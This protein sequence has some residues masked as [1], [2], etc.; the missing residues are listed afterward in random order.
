MRKKDNILLKTPFMTVVLNLLVIYISFMLCRVVFIWYNWNVF[1]GNLDKDVILKML[2]GALKFDTAGIMY[3]TLPYMLLTML[4]FHF[5]ENRTYYTI[6]KVILIILI[7]AGIAANLIDTVYF[8]VHNHKDSGRSTV[9]EAFSILY[10]QDRTSAGL[11][12]CERGWHK[13]RHIH[14]HQAHNH[15]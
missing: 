11:R 1:D 6:V 7:S 15:E 9:Q 10:R 14:K 12:I 5:K 4:P 8:P 13:R 2:P 3:L